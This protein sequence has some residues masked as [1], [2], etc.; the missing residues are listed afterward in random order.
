MSRVVVLGG[1]FGGMAVAARLAKTGHQVTLVERAATLGGALGSVSEEGFTWDAGPTHTL[2]PAVVRDLF[3]KTGRPVE[4]ELELEPLELL[5]EHRFEDDTILRLPSARAGQLRAWDALE[6]GLGQRWLGHVDSSTEDWEVLRHHYFEHPWDRT[7]VPA[8]VRQRLDSR[9][10]LHK[11]LRRTFKDERQR[12][13]A[14][15]PFL[16]DGHE[17]RNVPAWMGLVAFLEQRFGAWTVPGGMAGLG[18]VLAARLGTRKVQVL[19]GTRALDVVVRGGRAV[20]VRTSAGELEADEVVC[21]VDPRALP[22]LAP[23][24]ARTMPAI[25]P[26]T[27]H[28]GLEGEAPQLPH[29]VVLHGDPMLVVRTGGTAPEGR[30][31]WTVH[32]RGRL[33]ED[34]LR[35]LARARLDVRDHVVHRVDRSPREHVEAWSG[36]PLGVL[37][38]GRGTVRARLGPDTP[39][40]H[41]HAVG[42]HATPGS[43]LPFVGLSAALVAERIGPA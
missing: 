28:V 18:E 4:R 14:A 37:W 25:P 34:V 8:Q 26:V 35:A 15:Y 19:L 21:A 33:A 38:Q 41:L 6:P 9:E 12:E 10:M 24:V 7:S 11:R 13:V 40:A 20:G 39:I 2:L 42:A 27:C 16:A 36:S 17:L 5:R 32:G 30:H 22:A 1:G 3:R 43:G 31:A 29:E 23:A